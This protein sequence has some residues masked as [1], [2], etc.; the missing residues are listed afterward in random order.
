M[1]VSLALYSFL[2]CWTDVIWTLCHL[3]LA[4]QAPVPIQSSYLLTLYI[5]DVGSSHSWK[6]VTLMTIWLLWREMFWAL[7]R[8]Y[9]V[10]F[11]HFQPFWSFCVHW[12]YSGSV[13]RFPM[14]K[15]FPRRFRENYLQDAQV[16]AALAVGQSIR[17]KIS[18]LRRSW[19]N[20]EGRP[21][22]YNQNDSRL[23]YRTASSA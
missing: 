7:Q 13:R 21:T 4:S 16:R 20:Y 19:M 10:T 3:Y 1:G 15:Y 2:V 6:V 22:S 9:D 5:V 17:S 12:K 14:P 23:W 18:K 11:G 8:R